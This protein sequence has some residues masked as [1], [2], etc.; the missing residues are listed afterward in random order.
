MR[1]HGGMATLHIHEG[2]PLWEDAP[3][4]MSLKQIV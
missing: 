3:V 1:H 4:G 2:G